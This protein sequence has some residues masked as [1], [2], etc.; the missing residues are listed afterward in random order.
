MYN[1][2]AV[3][4]PSWMPTVLAEGA[5]IMIPEQ[6]AAART[7]AFQTAYAT[8]LADG[9]QSYFASLARRD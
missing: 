5:F 6:E 4:R 1:T 7:P 2:F 9:L 3:T 8:A